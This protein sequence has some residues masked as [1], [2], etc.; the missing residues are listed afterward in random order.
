MKRIGIVIAVLIAL[1]AP[2][3]ADSKAESL[4]EK[5]PTVET[6]ATGEAALRAELE[7]EYRAKLKERLDEEM[8]TYQASLTSLWASNAAVWGCLL[9]FVILSS[10]GARKRRQELERL[11][12]LREK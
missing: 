6:P 1:A 10:L 3:F 5:D 2:V 8:K 9:V 11:K 7:K 4:K 12:A